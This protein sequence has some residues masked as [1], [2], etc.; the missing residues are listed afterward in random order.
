MG[1][2]VWEVV[3]DPDVEVSWAGAPV[4]AVCARTPSPP[5]PYPSLAVPSRH[6]PRACRH[7]PAL[8]SGP[9]R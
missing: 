3:P 8:L 7:E 9:L 2:P 6:A 4:G 5:T 1:T